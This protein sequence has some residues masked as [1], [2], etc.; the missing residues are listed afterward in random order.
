MSLAGMTPGWL[1]GYLV[2]DDGETC[3]YRTLQVISLA[4]RE[5][6]D[7]IDAIVMEPGGKP[8]R[9]DDIPGR[10]FAVGPTEDVR[11]IALA[12]ASTMGRTKATTFG[13]RGAA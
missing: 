12:H 9:A 5:G 11:K 13:Q 1:I 10:A 2:S 7:E 8:M 3:T 4:A 6:G